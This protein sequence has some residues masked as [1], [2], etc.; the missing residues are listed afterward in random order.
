MSNSTTEVRR[1]STIPSEMDFDRDEAGYLLIKRPFTSDEDH[2]DAVSLSR[3]QAQTVLD[4]LYN[5]ATAL[6]LRLPKK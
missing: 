2:L 6:G 4:Y 5:H 3:E 1:G